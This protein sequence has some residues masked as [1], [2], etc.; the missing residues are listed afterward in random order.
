MPINTLRYFD[1]PVDNSPMPL[2]SPLTDPKR[3][4]T[5]IDV[6]G[7]GR[8]PVQIATKGLFSS[9]Y[10]NVVPN[11][12]ERI[13]HCTPS[14]PGD[15]VHPAPQKLAPLLWSLLGAC[16]GASAL[17]AGIILHGP[18]LAALGAVALCFSFLALIVNANPEPRLGDEGVAA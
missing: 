1:M 16:V 9:T 2:H 4:P 6:A 15:V 11:V 10:T 14:R 7:Y 5:H 13:L 18:A 12:A 17:T 3:C 8:I